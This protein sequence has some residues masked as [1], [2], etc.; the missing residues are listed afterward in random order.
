MGIDR[1]MRARLDRNAAFE[2]VGKRY[3]IDDPADRPR[4]P[5]D[6]LWP[7]QDLDGEISSVKS[8][9]KSKPPVVEVGQAMRMPSPPPPSARYRPHE[10]AGWSL[11]QPPLR[12]SVMPWCNRMSLTATGWAASIAGV[13][14]GDAG[15]DR[16]RRRA[17]DVTTISPLSPASAAWA[18]RQGPA[19]MG[20]Q[21]REESVKRTASW[22]AAR[23][24]GRQI[25]PRSHARGQEI[26]R[27]PQRM[28]H[29][30][31][32][33]PERAGDRA[34]HGCRSS[35]K[36]C[37]HRTPCRH[38]ERPRQAGLLAHGSKAGPTAGPGTVPG[39]P[40]A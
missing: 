18:A 28:T 10:C 11:R 38:E 20:R 37:S 27:I 7:A 34:A 14:H 29:N 6:R 30:R 23:H 8:L 1:P 26:P 21:G 13:E 2:R 39:I 35:G 40:M 19:R 9:A 36:P 25:A 32:T 33:L 24:N 22:A 16:S 5:Q 15:G 12:A 31:H 4:S 17:H 3:H